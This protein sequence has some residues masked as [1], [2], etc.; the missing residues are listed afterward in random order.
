MMDNNGRVSFTENDY[1]RLKEHY[2]GDLNAIRLTL[3][4]E[5]LKNIIC[6]LKG[7]EEEEITGDLV[8]KTAL[9]EAETTALNKKLAKLQSQIIPLDK[10]RYNL[11]IIAFT[12]NSG[13]VDLASQDLGISKRT[14]Y[15]DIIDFKIDIEAFRRKQ[16]VR[17]E[18][19]GEK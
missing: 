10:L 16:L 7:K 18:Q 2:G 19:E 9:E 1:V 4:I 6:F 11:E 15:R 17:S 13:D 14:L 5:E 3:S 8:F 12:K